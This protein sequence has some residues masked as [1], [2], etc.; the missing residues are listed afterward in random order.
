MRR[1]AAEDEDGKEEEEEEEEEEWG[2]L[3]R[4]C[5]PVRLVELASPPY[6]SKTPH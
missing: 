4:A 2:A 6:L 5:L 3:N 1:A